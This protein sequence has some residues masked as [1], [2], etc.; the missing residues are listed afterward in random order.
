MPKILVTKIPSQTVKF[1]NLKTEDSAEKTV[2]EAKVEEASEV[3]EVSV[4][5]LEAAVVVVA[6]V[7]VTEEI[8]VDIVAEEVATGKKDRT[9]TKMNQEA[10]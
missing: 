9:I 5:A 3:E 4:E 7:V 10:K 6:A 2:K 8:E 1:R